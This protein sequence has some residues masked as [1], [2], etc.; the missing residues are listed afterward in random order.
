MNIIKFSKPSQDV[1]SEELAWS[2]EEQKKRKSQSELSLKLAS[3]PLRKE[4]KLCR[5]SALEH[6]LEYVHRSIDYMICGTCS[7]IQCKH[8]IPNNYPEM[9]SEGG[10][11]KIYPLLSQKQFSSRVKRIYEPKL[12]WIISS[13][14]SLGVPDAEIYN[15]SGLEIGSGGGFFLSALL[16][17]N[18]RNVRGL[19]ENLDLVEQCNLRNGEAVSELSENTL[20]ELKQSDAQII[21]AFFVLEH[22]DD[23]H[24]FFQ[25]L[26][27]KP[28][29]TIFVFS[30]PTFGFATLLDGI[31]T[32]NA[33][34][35]L[36]NAV[37]TQLFTDQSIEY[38]LNLAGFKKKSEWLFGQDSHD[39]RRLL[40]CNIRK[41]MSDEFFNEQKKKFDE[42]IDEMQT[43]IDKSRYCDS[44]HVLAIKE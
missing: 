11:E 10:F 37:H 31:F 32:E 4:C 13:L 26:K 44:R 2:K 19:D 30:V 25:V 17:K 14:R 24:N 9:Y 27:T 21:V 41:N 6:S 40:L 1:A 18:I 43:V 12:D 38:A 20:S 22:I 39:L 29:G 36:D 5:N 34:R 16:V 35:N 23:L 42:F 8:E 3:F 33:A 15:S 7:H 28:R